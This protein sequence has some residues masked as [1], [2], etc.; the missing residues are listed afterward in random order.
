MAAPVVPT[1][2]ASTPPIAKMI[3]FVPGVA[4]MATS[5]RMAP[6]IV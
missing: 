3:A 1:K 2:L 4:G 5:M 6:P